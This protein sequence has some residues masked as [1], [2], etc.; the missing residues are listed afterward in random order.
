M[1]NG[2]AAGKPT[3]ECHPPCVPTAQWGHPMCGPTSVRGFVAAE[4]GSQHL[5]GLGWASLGV[6]ELSALPTI[7]AERWV[8]W[9]RGADV[10]LV[11]GGELILRNDA[12]GH[13]GHQCENTEHTEESDDSRPTDICAFLGEPGVHAG[14][15]DAQEH[16]Y[17][18]QHRARGLVPQRR[19]R[20][21]A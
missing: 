21:P 10:L 16:E 20:I 7:G 5:S 2:S 6:L 3:A 8:P 15:L 17:G 1:A 18:D 12:V 11:D 9:V 19:S 14:T 13:Q 4:P